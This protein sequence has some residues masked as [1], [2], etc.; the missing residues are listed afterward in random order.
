VDAYQGILEYQFR[1]T[2]GNATLGSILHYAFAFKVRE[3]KR[4]NIPPSY[5]TPVD[6][7]CHIIHRQINLKTFH[8]PLMLPIIE[9]RKR[10]M[11]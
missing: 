7:I 8:A 6:Q 1:I 4:A 11:L 9:P 10:E 5:I 3:E 2:S